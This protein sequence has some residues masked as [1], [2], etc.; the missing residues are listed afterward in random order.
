MLQLAP[1]QYITATSSTT[2]TSYTVVGEEGIVA[3]G[4]FY[5]LKI[6][7]TATSAETVSLLFT[8]HN[9]NDDTIL[10]VY[11]G[12]VRVYTATIPS[13]GSVSFDGSWKMY[14]AAGMQMLDSGFERITVSEIAP[15]NPSIGDLWVQI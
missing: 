13:G 15:S 11:V 1:G 5:T 6:L 14:N 8:N 7:Y 9:Q 4:F 12:E 2:N 3:Q 10:T